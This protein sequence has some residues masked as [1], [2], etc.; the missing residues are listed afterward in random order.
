MCD[1]ETGVEKFMEI[2]E[3]KDPMRSK[4]FAVEMGFLASCAARMSSAYATGATVLGDSW[5][6]I[7]KVYVLAA[8]LVVCRG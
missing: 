5:I 3:G 2:Q 8:M 1:T 6:G 7:I 4:P